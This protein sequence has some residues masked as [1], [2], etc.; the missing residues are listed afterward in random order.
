VDG[1]R[2][3]PFTNA[4]ANPA[5]SNLSESQ[6]PKDDNYRQVVAEIR[7]S[8]LFKAS[9]EKDLDNL[10]KQLIGDRVD[11]AL[12]EQDAQGAYP[13]HRA[14]SMANV[15]AIKL[16]LAVD[17]SSALSRD[18]AGRTPLHIV[19]SNAAMENAAEHEQVTRREIIE[20][21]LTA[22]SALEE[23]T[24]PED[25]N[26]N[27]PWHCLDIEND[28]HEWIAELRTEYR[29]FISMKT[30]D[31]KPRQLALPNQDLKL[32][33]CKKSKAILAQFYLNEGSKFDFVDPQECSVFKV[34][35]DEAY[36]PEA[37]FSRELRKRPDGKR[38]CRWIHL[39]A[40][41]VSLWSPFLTCSNPEADDSAFKEEWVQVCHL[42]GAFRWQTV[43]D[44]SPCRICS[45]GLNESIPP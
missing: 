31:R 16:L 17:P 6:G 21:L 18:K 9:E 25:G 12:T 11:I 38:T 36:G 34:I 26:G 44:I 32:R 1:V 15:P 20:Q 24:D 22:L 14:A 45:F 3:V 2:F 19:A 28:N 10:L 39:P 40:N 43:F 35:Y 37:L 5:R 13:I 33:A 8:L 23:S 27:T 42:N 30:I 7:R 29:S 41:N 4:A